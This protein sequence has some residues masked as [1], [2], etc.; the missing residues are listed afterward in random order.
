[1]LRKRVG[2][3]GAGAPPAAFKDGNIRVTPGP[4]AGEG[5]RATRTE[6]K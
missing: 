6:L 1:L 2:L 5:A 3:C 4:D